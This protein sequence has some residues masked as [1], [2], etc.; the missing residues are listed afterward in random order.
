MFAQ[1]LEE[2]L[3]FGRAS[4]WGWSDHKI[5]LELCW[6]HSCRGHCSVANRATKMRDFLPDVCYNIGGLKNNDVHDK[7]SP[8][9]HRTLCPVKTYL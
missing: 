1:S 4:A 2:S 3:A 7:V 9:Q 5:F 8:T 6:Q